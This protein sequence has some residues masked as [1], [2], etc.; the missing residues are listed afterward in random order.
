MW[1]GFPKSDATWEHQC[2][3]TPEL[4]RYYA[5]PPV[6][7]NNIAQAKEQIFSGF[8]RILQ[9]KSNQSS[10]IEIHMRLDVFRAITRE[11]NPSPGGV[12]G[13]LSYSKEDIAKIGLPEGWDRLCN[14]DLYGQ[15]LF[16]P[17]LM[18]AH[19]HYTPENHVR[20]GEEVVRI[21][22]F[23]D[24]RVLVRACTDACRI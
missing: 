15:C 11:C 21:P 3:L 19:V 6:D 13:Y 10:Y 8:Q 22:P 12:R 5:D 23:P 9:G 7:Q 18:K 17:I 4:L 2:H 1:E 16:F 24:E 14:K 20:R